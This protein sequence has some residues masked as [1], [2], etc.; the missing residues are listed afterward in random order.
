L[1]S[2]LG[3]RADIEGLRAIAVLSVVLFH[4]QPQWVVGGFLGVDIFFVISGFLITFIINREIKTK[5]FS[6]LT[7][8]KRRARRLLPVYFFILFVIIL[9]GLFILLPNDFRRLLNSSV[10]STLFSSNLYFALQGGYFENSGE[11][12]LLHT[13]SLSVEEQ[14]YFI[15]PAIL[16]L[17]HKLVKS[18]VYKN[19][20]FLSLILTSLLFGSL[21]ATSDEFSQWSYFLLPTRMGELLIGAYVA[22]NFNRIKQYGSSGYIG[23]IIL[24]L[25]F[26]FIDESVLFPGLITLIPCL[27]V[28]LIL[29]NPQ[30]NFVYSILS[31]KLLTHIGKLSYSIYLW[32]WPIVA[33]IHYFKGSDEI[34]VNET[35]FALTIIYLLSLFSKTFVED[36][37][38][39]INITRTFKITTFTFVLPSLLLFCVFLISH[40]TGGFKHRIPSK[41]LDEQ[42]T[43]YNNIDRCI[44][45]LA[46][47]CKVTVNKPNE[48]IKDFILF[49]D[50]H[51]AQLYG[52][53]EQ[54]NEIEPMNLYAFS[55]SSCTPT[56]INVTNNCLNTRDLFWNNVAEYGEVIVAAKW[57]D[58]LANSSD[59]NDFE[60]SLINFFNKLQSTRK[61][62]TIFTQVPEYI[63]NPYRKYIYREVYG[64][65]NKAILSSKSSLAN[66]ILRKVSKRY[67]K[68]NLIDS[69]KLMCKTGACQLYDEKGNILYMDNDHLNYVGAKF[70]ANVYLKIEADDFK[71]IVIADL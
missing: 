68:F 46:V 50:S 8:Y 39:T 21:L 43:T 71:N 4:F 25:S 34:S 56:V 29:T 5:E 45:S 1:S 27:G 60:E 33:Y 2:K 66:I 20:L 67:P 47:K 30:N 18:V 65:N 15:W 14:F 38:R 7:F 28:V 12:P 63:S 41:L 61:N 44:D 26:Y 40:Q 6:F 9:A 17:I 37:F 49:G 70:L 13:W 53:F 32:H 64:L 59:R 35:T 42:L 48:I 69:E 51:S 54:I 52:F 62:I 10:A 24:L 22:I 19:V 23:L 3:Y 36:K 57:S 11:Y 31:N 58:G 16:L 55:S